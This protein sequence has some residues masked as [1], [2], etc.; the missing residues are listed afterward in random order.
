MT[1]TL[2]VNGRRVQVDAGFRNLSPEQQQAAVEEIAASMGGNDPSALGWLNRG[3]SGGLDSIVEGVNR[4]VNAAIRG[5]ASLMGIDDPYQF[6]TSPVAD[7]MDIA[8]IERATQ[9]PQTLPQHLMTGAG[10]AAGYM[11]P[12]AG[13]ARGLGALGGVT[14]AVGQA[15]NAPLVQAPVR[16]MM[17][18]L[19]AGGGARV[20]GE[21]AADAAGG[22]Y[23]EI[24]RPFGELAGAAAGAMGPAAAA[25]GVGAAADVATRYAPGLSMARAAIA[26]EIAPFTERGARQIASQRLRGLSEDPTGQAAMLDPNS[27]L[28]SAQQTGDP[29]LMAL[30]R[31]IIEQNPTLRPDFEAGSLQAQRDLLG[32]AR[33][34]MGDVADA[35]RVIDERTQGVVSRLQGRIAEAE[36][37]AQERVAALSP[38][39][40]VSENSTIVR[41]EIDRAFNAARAEESRLWR[42]IPD[43]VMVPTGSARQALAD[44]L[45]EA[46]E[47][48]RHRVPELARRWLGH[49]GFA[50]QV[51]AQEAHRLYSEMRQVAR[52]AMA[53]TPDEFTARLAG[54]IANA[55]LRDMDS[56]ASVGEP[57]AAARA[58]T[59]A[60]AEAFEQGTVGRLLRRGRGGGDMVDPA[61]ALDRSIGTGGTRGAVAVDDI[62]AAA[63]P[64]VDPPIEDYLRNQMFR[65]GDFTPQR[66]DS[67]AR[68]NEELLGRYPE[69]ARAL[70]EAQEATGAAGRASERFGGIVEA[71][72]DPRRSAGAAFTA[73]DPGREMAKSVFGAPNPAT[74]ARQIAQ[75]VRRDPAARAGLKGGAVDELFARASSGYST[76]GD[77]LISGNTLNGMLQ[78]NQTRAALAHILDPQELSRMDRIARELQK[79]ERSRAS[80]T[81]PGVLDV[82]PNRLIS[83]IGGTLAA[84]SGAQLG[85]GTSGASLRT[86][87]RATQEFNRIM[88]NLTGKRAERLIRT[89]I[90]EDP[91]LFKALMENADTPAKVASVERRIS[92]WLKGYAASGT[93]DENSGLIEALMGQ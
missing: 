54:G 18:E 84:R 32:Q 42:E 28:T 16:S 72:V 36:A 50:D 34:G 52:E 39:R 56:V 29:N 5:G 89:A 85:A 47:V 65:R 27:P 24:A 53:D 25:R 3:I 23:G 83:Y 6:G 59:R 22:E 69:I 71:L 73:A 41:E 79:L 35:R 48:S 75:Q 26:R 67:F 76:E 38:Q 43:N 2:E 74:A 77:R 12:F 31:T 91:D 40:A 9:E 19:L 80:G 61:L 58:Q 63:G 17:A 87:S 60:M 8:G 11:I 92:E 66:A 7:L 93:S 70:A 44:A 1:V 30:E 64:A 68:A 45:Q 62:R 4:P 55:I 82:E 51:P 88:Q 37:R 57:F 14:G 20:G 86:A 49:N 46:G 10:E 33:E 21:M 78:D 13:A 81:L 15:V 90:T